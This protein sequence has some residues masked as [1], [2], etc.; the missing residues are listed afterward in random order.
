MDTLLAVLHSLGAPVATPQDVPSAWRQRRQAWWQRLL[1]PIAVAWEGEPPPL[2]LRLPSSNSNALGKCHLKLESGEQRRWEWRG[3]DQPALE[4]AEVEGKQYVIKHLHLPGKLPWG[5]HYLSLELA[6]RSQETLIISAPAKAYHPPLEPENRTWGVF[7]PLHALHTEKS[8]GGGDFSALESLT[9]WVAEVGGRIVATL[10]LLTTFMDKTSQPSPYLP[11]S[12]LLWNEFYLDIT[13]V[14][15]W[16]RSSPAQALAA[17]PSFQKEIQALRDSPLVDYHR[18]MALKRQVLE[19]MCHCLFAQPSSRLEALRRFAQTNPAVE[20][21]ARFRAAGEKQLIPWPSW[22]QPLRD[23]VL[24]EGDYSE[25]NKRYHL[26]VQWLAHEQI[27][28][29]SARAQE[30]D[31]RLY[32]D[33]PLGVH[34]D[35]YDTWR[36]RGLFALNTSAGAPPDSAFT[37]GQNWGFPPLHPEKNREQHYRYTIA[38]LRHHLQYAGI[39]RI[40]HMM[41]LHR[42]F[43][44]PE[45]IEASQGAYVRYPAE[46]L[47]AILTLESHRNRATIVGE[48]LGT[49]PPCVRPAMKEH[50]IQRMYVVQYEL[51]SN[52]QAL[53]PVPTSS[54][55]SLNT[56]DMPPFAAFWEGSDIKE[57]LKLGLLDRAGA[58]REKRTRRN[59][60]KA[61]TSFL[62]NKGLIKSQVA[63]A[64]DA[65][66]ACLAFLSAS[67]AR[68]VLVNLEDLWLETRPQN[69][70]ST[71]EECPNWRRKARYSFEQFCQM[72]RVTDT[73]HMINQLRKESRRRR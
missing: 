66:R 55:A 22:P 56:H 8:W 1:E 13:G 17:S 60:R 10:P 41:G 42:L 62:R 28:V 25:E 63:D 50:G 19:E 7:L 48:D 23:G 71:G 61:L 45:G 38:Y 11:L 27:Q 31:L 44:I 58:Q 47:Y 65:V 54:V 12:R 26:Y 4:T 9:S 72:P 24:R 29:L 21:Y 69:V 59:T 3:A 68:V 39:L 52:H 36:E 5:Y 2:K 51:A 14:P 34:P 18:Q 35:G 16:Q 32:L 20:D 57:R 46:E 73:L 67:R 49:V 6:G 30:K 15:E 70:P 33:L 43:W 40:D 37:R 64:D 53:N